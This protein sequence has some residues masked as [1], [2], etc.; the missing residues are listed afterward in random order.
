MSDYTRDPTTPPGA[1]T[2][3]EGAFLR[4]RLRHVSWGAI[5]AGLIIA[6][7]LQILLGLLGIGL[8]L[9]ILNPS[10]PVGG[11]RAWGIAT[12][13]Y[14]VVVQ[15][16][17]LFAGGYIAARLAPAL[18]DQT[19]MFHG[20]TIWALAT[21]IMVWIGGTTVGLAFSGLS[22]AISTVGSATTSAVETVIPDDISLPDLDYQSLPEPLRET[23][24]ENGIT[25]DNFQQELRG[26]YRDVVSPQEEQRVMREL[27]EAI[28]AILQSPGSAPEEIDQ[29]MDNIFGR[30][31][32]LSEEDLNQVENTLQERLDLSDQEVQQITNQVQQSIDQTREAVRES[33]QTAR[34]EAREAA[35]AASDA[36]ASIALWLFVA[37][38][39]ALIA[40][41]IGGKVGEVKTRV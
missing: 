11:V 30:G 34:Q 23:L 5:F 7:A 41:V 20:L 36:I 19:A 10:D 1:V 17:S 14:V 16:I 25:P 26:A 8:G 27:R 21:I 29:A 24:R 37:N 12:S 6:I 40:A 31:G 35:E 22:N 4:E 15:I 9:Q 33:V 32:I 18:T 2:P 28:Q 13:L 39:L 38:L 3:A